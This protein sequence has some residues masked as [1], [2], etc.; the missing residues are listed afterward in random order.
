MSNRSSLYLTSEKSNYLLLEANN[1]LPFY[2]ALL[3][4]DDHIQENRD[5]FIAY[6]HGNGENSSFSLSSEDIETNSK[7]SILYLKKHYPTYVQR[8]EE[9]AGYVEKVAKQGTIELD[10]L[11]IANFS[12]PEE[13]MDELQALTSKI[14]NQEPLSDAEKNEYLNDDYFSLVGFDNYSNHHDRYSS[15]SQ[16]YAALIEQEKATQKREYQ[17]YTQKTRKENR[18]ALV[19]NIIPMGVIG[20]FFLV[21]GIFILFKEPNFEPKSLLVIGIGLSAL[22][23]VYYKLKQAKYIK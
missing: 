21:G 6:Y 13:F 10:I 14:N 16:S 5:R 12:S 2:W 8:F 3:M 22:I 9:F 20:T 4:S 11:E 7:R 17:D 23:Y 15:Y 1:Y 18:K 19:T